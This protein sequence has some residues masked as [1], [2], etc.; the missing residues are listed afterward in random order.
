MSQLRVLQLPNSLNKKSGV[1]SVIMNF[2]RNID[3][4]KIQ[5]DFLCFESDEENYTSEITKLGGKIFFIDSKYKKNFFKMRQEIGIFLSTHT[6]TIIHYHATS[7]WNL[8]LKLGMDIGIPNRIAHSHSTTYSESKLGTVRNRFFSRNL[9]KEANYYLACST[10]A[11]ELLFRNKQFK[12]LHNAIDVDRF[13]Y[14]PVKRE[15][16]R[17]NLNLENHYVI[18]HV[19][20]FSAQKNHDYLI[21]LFYEYH[22]IN[23]RAKLLLIGEGPLRK[24]IEEKINYLKLN[25]AVSIVDFNSEIENYYQAMDIFVMP[26]L[27]EGL[28]VSGIEAQA[29]GL[30]CLFS[31]AISD[32]VAICE[33]V[34]FF[35]TDR[36]AA[37]NI[38]LINDMKNSVVREKVDPIVK[39]KKYDI[40]QEA[41]GLQDFYLSMIQK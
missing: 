39:K 4:D 27:Y 38:F 40:K 17:K 3:R 20:R 24:E 11:G 6:Y 25:T 21:D 35:D 19:G 9:V 34:A 12:L 30:P 29:S 8:A 33:N 36:K 15:E 22:K 2:Y 41:T 5:F 28:P 18:G 23:D 37:E 32:E 10:E 16:I 13:S 7:I 14:N 31:K 1:M 26:S